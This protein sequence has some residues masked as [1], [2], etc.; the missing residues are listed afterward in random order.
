M[1]RRRFFGAAAVPARADLARTG[2]SPSSGGGRR[3]S[4][5]SARSGPANSMYVTR[6]GSPTY[7]LSRSREFLS[8]DARAYGSTADAPYRVPMA[9]DIRSILVRARPFCSSRRPNRIV[10]GPPEKQASDPAGHPC[11][12]EPSP[13]AQRQ[14]STRGRRLPIRHRMPTLVKSWHTQTENT[15]ST[16]YR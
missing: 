14:R 1:K 10:A 13:A 8:Y 5:S 11:A 16:R 3:C 7:H 9:D 6:V 15:H 4:A 12:L 2:T